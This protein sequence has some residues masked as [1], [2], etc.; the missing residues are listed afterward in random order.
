MVP[1]WCSDRDLRFTQAAFFPYIP[2]PSNPI[3]GLP[4]LIAL[5]HL[6]SLELKPWTLQRLLFAPD[7][8]FGD[9]NQPKKNPYTSEYIDFACSL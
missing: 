9:G 1:V 4:H 8:D 3:Q 6:S 7:T 2:N 5:G